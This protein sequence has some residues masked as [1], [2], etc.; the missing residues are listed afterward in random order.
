MGEFAEL[1]LEKIPITIEKNEFCLDYSDIFPVNSV[2][3]IPY[4]YAYDIVE[5]KRGYK[6]ELG[7]IS[8][9]L[10]IMGY[11]ITETKKII[12]G[13]INEWN[14]QEYGS[15]ITF[16][17]FYKL[18]MTINWDEQDNLST[19]LEHKNLEEM[20]N[21]IDPRYILQILAQ[22]TKNLNKYVTWGLEDVVEGGY[23]SYENII[24]SK[25]KNRVLIATEGRTDKNI[26]YQTLLQLF[27]NISDLFYF[28]TYSEDESINVNGCQDLYRFC[29]Y[30][31]QMKHSYVIALFDNDVDGNVCLNKAKSINNINNLLITRLPDRKEFEYFEIENPWDNNTYENINGRAVAIENFLDFNSINERPIVKLENSNGQGRLLQKEKYQEAFNKAA[32]SKILSTNKYNTKKLESLIVE[33]VSQWIDYANRNVSLF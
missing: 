10:S 4:Y 5:H 32:N 6:A 20:F 21:W 27:P 18:L 29:K 12:N 9:R 33:L 11:T 8:Q 23:V 7:V 17:E 19:V 14:D 1:R 15:H 16:A 31:S 30:I 24:G 28:F 2:T 13:Y 3:D 22:N 25:T 26:L